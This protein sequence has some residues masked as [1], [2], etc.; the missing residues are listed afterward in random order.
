MKLLYV[1]NMRVPTEKAHGAQ[2][3]KT[4]EALAAQGVEVEL[5]ATDRFTP[6][7]EDPFA[8]YGIEKPFPLVLLPVP[9]IVSWGKIGFWI[10]S[11]VFALRA[12]A[13]ARRTRPDII[14]GRD[15]LVLWLLPGKVVWEP[16]RGAWNLAARVLSRRAHKIITISQGLKDYF[17]SWGVDAKRIAVAHD[18]IDLVPFGHTLSKEESRKRLGLPPGV[19]L[20]M[21]AGRLDGWKGTDTLLAAAKDI[22]MELAIIGGEPAQVA[23]HRSQFPRV[24][25]LDFRPYRELANNLAAADVLVLP[26]TGKDETS[27]RFTSPLKLFAYM[28][29][30]KP[31][32]AADLASIREVIDEE[33][34]YFFEPD[35]PESL[36]R[37][38]ARAAADP[39]APGRAVL[40][41]E[42]V[43]A[44]SWNTRARHI[45]DFL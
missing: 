32:V 10:E 20:A 37:S 19:P 18:G 4:C 43:K 22:P 44:Y 12:R 5:V 33:C 16:H 29:A 8:Y 27:A 1:A 3:F 36:A 6:V 35:N 45:I 41:R 40:A 11:F 21:Y 30:G 42:R 38:V 15:E 7:H 13:H 25:F 17:V 23:K 14:Y 24:H 39:G 9:D 26:N 28:A 2:I 31:I 34:A